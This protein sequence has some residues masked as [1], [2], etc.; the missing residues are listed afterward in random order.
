MDE[1]KI[2]F[3]Q[4]LRESPTHKKALN[5]VYEQ[6]MISRGVPPEEIAKAITLV[7]GVLTISFLDPYMLIPELRNKP[8]HAI[9][10]LTVPRTTLN[11]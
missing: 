9:A 7:F 6:A 11:P 10:D 1:E 2:S 4:L 5:F 8:M 3:L